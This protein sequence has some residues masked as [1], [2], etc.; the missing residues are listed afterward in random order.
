MHPKKASGGEVVRQTGTPRAT[1]PSLRR[2]GEQIRRRTQ[3]PIKD[4][5]PGEFSPVVCWR[6]AIPKSSSGLA[7]E[8]KT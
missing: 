2:G 3:A 1:V 8:D 6:T 5:G 4:Q 7:N